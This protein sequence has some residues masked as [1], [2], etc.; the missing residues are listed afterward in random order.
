MENLEKK[1]VD[2]VTKSDIE[3]SKAENPENRENFSA[4]FDG[5]YITII[6]SKERIKKV[7]KDIMEMN[8]F[9]R[10]RVLP[11]LIKDIEIGS[12]YQF[13]VDILTPSDKMIRLLGNSSCREGYEISL[14]G[15]GNSTSPEEM[16][17]EIEKATELVF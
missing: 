13:N 9:N 15:G 16:K 5:E 7:V 3:K 8:E 10:K 17:E 4:S 12:D 6:G 2:N 11:A 1:L 14:G